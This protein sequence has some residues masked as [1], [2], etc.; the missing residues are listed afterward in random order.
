VWTSQTNPAYVIERSLGPNKGSKVFLWDHNGN[1]GPGIRGVASKKYSGVRGHRVVGRRYPKR[2]KCR[3]CQTF[4]THIH[5]H[6]YF[7]EIYIE[8]HISARLTLCLQIK[9]AAS[10]WYAMNLP[11]LYLNAE[12]RIH[13]R[14]KCCYHCIVFQILTCYTEKGK[15]YNFNPPSES[16]SD[17][18]IRNWLASRDNALVSCCHSDLMFSYGHCDNK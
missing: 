12:Q 10:H 1:M 18:A 4:S 3:V 14:F 11:C 5:I 16:R 6:I 17:P 15:D 8:I 7:P 9:S 13:I 2:S